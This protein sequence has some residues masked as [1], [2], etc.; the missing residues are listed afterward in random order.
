LVVGVLTVIAHVA[1]RLTRDALPDV[2]GRPGAHR[3]PHPLPDSPLVLVAALARR[4]GPIT[5]GLDSQVKPGSSDATSRVTR[6]GAARS[7]VEGLL[8]RFEWEGAGRAYRL[9]YADGN[10]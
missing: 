3:L 2:P 10:N 4:H 7:R 5:A 8:V 6:P 9:L 1:Q